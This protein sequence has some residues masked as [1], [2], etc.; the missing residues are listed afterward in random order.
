MG[1][2]VKSVKSLLIT[3]IF[4]T[5][6]S[7]LAA[8]ANPK[9]A[10]YIIHADTGDV[11]FDRY[12]T[13]PRYPASLT[14]M[15]TLYLLFE[16]IEEGRVSRTTDMKVSK[17]ASLQP[18][19]K[20]G[21]KSGTTIDVDTAIRALVIKSANDVA[22]VTAEHLAGSE[23]KFARLMTQKARDLGMRQ[24]VFRNASGLPDDRQVTTARDMAIL[25]QRLVQ[26]FPDFFHYFDDDS[27][28]WGGRTYKSHN[29]VT[30]DLKGADGLKTGYTRASGYN[31]AT[32]VRRGDHR[33][34]GI[35]LGG[36]SGRTRNA[37]M[38]EI[39]NKAYADI[40]AR[41]SLVKSI[42]H[43][44]PVPDLR[45]DRRLPPSEGGPVLLSML[46]D[47]GELAELEAALNALPLDAAPE[48]EGDIDYAYARDWAIQVGAF[49]SQPLAVRQ[50]IETQDLIRSVSSH[51]GREVNIADQGVRSVYRARFTRLT[52]DEAQE[53]CERLKAAGEEC[54]ALHITE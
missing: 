3:I 53:S 14:K 45:P 1:T 40:S 30:Q 15:M 23:A 10:A 31:L 27:F 22:T 44:K 2:R 19:S 20:L 46:D 8:H 6:L 13:E 7:P 35:V 42:L 52:E 5:V 32:T 51:I 41:P 9:Y 26:D 50:I 36:R 29:K 54:I 18:A 38:I 28:Q 49:N 47:D 4:A 12:S 34:I 48:G 21:V 16:A 37:H 17:R 43:V 33:L 24:T 39:M 11:L 25:S